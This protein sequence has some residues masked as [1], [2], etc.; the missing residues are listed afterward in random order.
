MIKKGKIV[1]IYVDGTCRVESIDVPG[2][3]SAPLKVQEGIDTTNS[4]LSKD[5]EVVY[6]LFDDQTGVILGRM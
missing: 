2:D 3:I 6:V 1:S 4:P 5:D